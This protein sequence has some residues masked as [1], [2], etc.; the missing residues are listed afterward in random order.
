[1]LPLVESIGAS[2][3]WWIPEESGEQETVLILRCKRLF[4]PLYGEPYPSKGL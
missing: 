1:M 4:S 3:P 2:Q